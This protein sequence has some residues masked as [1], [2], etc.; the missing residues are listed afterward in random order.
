M[1]ELPVRNEDFRPFDEAAAAKSRRHWDEVAKPL[2]SLGR[3]EEAVTRIIG[4]TSDPDYTIEKRAVLTLCADNGVVQQGVTM[5][6]GAVTTILTKGLAQNCL[7]VNTM[8]S[9]AGAEVFTVDMGI[10]QA[11]EIDGLINRRIGPGTN[12]F[13]QG[14]AM[15][16]EQAVQGIQTGIEL[17]KDLKDKGY[18]II[19]TGEAGIGNTTSSSALAAVFL[20]K[21]VSE[22]TG[23]GVGLSDEGLAKKI[24][25]IET[26]IELNEP[27]PSDPIDVISKLGGFDIAGMCGIFLGGAKYQ[28][29][30]VVD[31]IISSVSALSALRLFPQAHTTMVASHQSAEPAAAAL[32]QALDLKPLITAEMRVGE[33]TGAVA[34]LPL[35][36]MA[37]A[38]YHNTA[39]Y[40]DLGIG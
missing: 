36:D 5:T 24:A 35:L 29:P 31:G 7:T 14:P 26:A 13:S 1:A 4:A 40:S 23:R 2:G 25:T 20:N 6:P 37:F 15:T 21:T 9:V 34:V 30:I 39:T 22:V 11:L 3:L 8:A 17:V 19:C 28:V 10:A 33:G 18:K 16:R 32:L 27:N 12:D 38:V